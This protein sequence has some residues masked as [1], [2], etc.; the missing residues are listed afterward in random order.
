MYICT[1]VLIKI[2]FFLNSFL[3]KI[4]SNSSQ[5]LGMRLYRGKV[6]ESLRKFNQ[7]V[8]SYIDNICGD[9]EKRMFLRA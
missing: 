8:T 2:V 5:R 4:Y 3:L 1:C 7:L 9:I 6:K